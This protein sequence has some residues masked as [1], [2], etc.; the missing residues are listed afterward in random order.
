MEDWLSRVIGKSIISLYQSGL[1]AVCKSGPSI[2]PFKLIS[3]IQPKGVMEMQKENMAIKGGLA[4]AMTLISLTMFAVAP[5][6]AIVRDNSATVSSIMNERNHLLIKEQ[7]LLEDYDDLQ[8]QLRDLQKRD[9]DK[10]AVDQ[11]CRDID[12]KYSDLGSVRHNIKQ[13]E[14]RL[15]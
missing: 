4:L 10:R 13:L 5:S 11:L 3:Y 15:M 8:R 9:T 2:G 14:M 1:V 6:Q 12:A 7:Q